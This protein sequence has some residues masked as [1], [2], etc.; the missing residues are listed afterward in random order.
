MFFIYANCI[1]RDIILGKKKNPDS[2]IYS[3]FIGLLLLNS[4]DS[5]IAYSAHRSN[6]FH[7]NDL[8]WQE[9]TPVHIAFSRWS[10]AHVICIVSERFS[11][12]LVRK[13]GP[14]RQFSH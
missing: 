5:I 12:A 13:S 4:I 2:G 3:V 14:L 9:L 6:A 1:K 8:F 11:C 10:V 7:T